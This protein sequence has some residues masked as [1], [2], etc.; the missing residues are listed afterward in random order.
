MNNFDFYNPTK[1]LFGEGKIETITEEIP[2]DAKVLMTYGGG[3]I[4]QNG[5]YEQATEVFSIPST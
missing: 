3:S 1:I 2:D 4:K 5:I